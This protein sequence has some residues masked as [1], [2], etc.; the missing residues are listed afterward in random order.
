MV[1]LSM[2]PL[3]VNGNLEMLKENAQG[4]TLSMKNKMDHSKIHVTSFIFS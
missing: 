1:T 2:V 3:H 4:V